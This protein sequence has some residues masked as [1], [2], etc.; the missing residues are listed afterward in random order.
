M[1]N[2]L[3]QLNRL[4]GSELDR[5]LEEP[6]PPWMGSLLREQFASR[7]D[8]Q[9]LLERFPGL[10]RLWPLPGERLWPEQPPM[11]EPG[12]AEPPATLPVFTQEAE[13]NDVVS[14]ASTLQVGIRMDARIG[15]FADADWFRLENVAVGSYRLSFDA[16]GSGIGWLDS[17]RIGIGDADG[18]LLEKLVVSRQ[19]EFRLDV[20]VPM[21]SLTLVVQSATGLVSGQGAYSIQVDAAAQVPTPTPAVPTRE[22]E[23]NDTQAQADDLALGNSLSASLDHILGDDWFRILPDADGRLRVTLDTRYDSRWFKRFDFEVVDADGSVLQQVFTGGDA[24]LEVDVQRGVP[25]FARVA[26]VGLLADASPYVVAVSTVTSTQPVLDALTGTRRADLLVGTAGDDLI[27]GQ[28][29]DDRVDGRDGT[30][31]VVFHVDLSALDIVSAE[32][33]TVVRG[34]AAAGPYAAHAVRIWN[35]EMLAAD[36]QTIA[37]DA[38]ADER[39]RRVGTGRGERLEGGPGD[40]VLD[41][42]GGSDTVFGG[43]GSD[44]WVLLGKDEDFA[45]SSI[46][47]IARVHGLSSG[48]E[49]AGSLSVATGVERIVTASGTMVDV[50]PARDAIAVLGTRSRDLLRGTAADEVFDGLGGSDVIDGA[51]GHDTLVL[52]GPRA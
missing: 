45:I 20:Q 36:D 35:V 13:P 40:D 15:S 3:A 14:R 25:I 7:A 18:H 48:D 49:Y 43:D 51:A 28:G 2:V 37:L 22:S 42:A 24:A 32:G 11:E 50:E 26:G 30:D 52:F 41:G 47:G 38:V 8:W 1:T 29:G 34:T 16:A 6:L 4:F 33:L 10:D 44:T 12:A 19:G 23:P 21:E 27:D 17:Y 39:V 46:A 5:L 9:T 31:T